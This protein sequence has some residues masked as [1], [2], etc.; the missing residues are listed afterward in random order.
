MYLIGNNILRN[1][2]L[3][4]LLIH[5][6]NGF[7]W[8]EEDFMNLELPGICHFRTRD[9]TEANV[10]SGKTEFNLIFKN[11]WVGVGGMRPRKDKGFH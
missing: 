5:V 4:P 2:Q 11:R 9:W 10:L 1:K 6:K 8:Q 7:Y 3:F